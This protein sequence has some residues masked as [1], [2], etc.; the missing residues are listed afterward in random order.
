MLWKLVKPYNDANYTALVIAYLLKVETSTNFNKLARYYVEDIKP[1]DIRKQLHKGYF[2]KNFKLWALKVIKDNLSPQQALELTKKFGVSKSDFRFFKVFMQSKYLKKVKK[3]VE[4]RTIHTIPKLD[5]F[6]V[7]AILSLDDYIKKFVRK[8]LIFITHGGHFTFDDIVSELRM[9]GIYAAYQQYP[10]VDS[11]LHLTNIMKRGIH[12]FGINMIKQ[13]TTQ[14]RQVLHRN[15][16]GTF[17]GL[18]MSMSASSGGY[19]SAIGATDIEGDCIEES[20]ED[21]FETSIDS[22]NLLKSTK[23]LK[24][25]FL[26]LHTGIFNQDF[27]DYL[28]EVGINV[29]NDEW[30]DICL[31]NDIKDYTNQCADYLNVTRYKAHT[32]LNELRNEA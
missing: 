19:V 22:I 24:R 1:I 14:S 12:N 16:D 27:S 15:D 11:Y 6:V 30:F 13:N 3:L 26:I 20:S 9:Y 29:P 4:S 18:K 2:I 17:S 23:G 7:K 5:S 28:V 8:K 25:D 21:D 32:F 10:L 31:R